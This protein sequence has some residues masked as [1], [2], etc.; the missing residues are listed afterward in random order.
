MRRR[1]SCLVVVML[2]FSMPATAAEAGAWSGEPLRPRAG[3]SLREPDRRFVSDVFARHYDRQVAA[4]CAAR[5]A[6]RADAAYQIGWLLLNA[7]QSE[8]A[9]AWLQQAAALGHERAAALL[10]RVPRS[11]H[12]PAVSCPAPARAPAATAG[13]AKP[14]LAP[15]PRT[16]AIVHKV[17]PRYGLDP[18]LV[19]AVIAVES[20][21]RA[22]A[23]SPKNARGLMQL[24]PE[25]AERFAVAD[26]FDPVQNIRG[27]ARYLS[28]L[29]DLFE[30]D[31]ALALAGYNAGENTVRRYGGVPPFAETRTY[32]RAVQ[33]YYEQLKLA[34]GRPAGRQAAGLRGAG[35]TAEA[36][37]LAGSLL[38]P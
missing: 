18:D 37:R 30:G 29:L 25:T 20:G 19:I 4:Y 1:V 21:F 5:G 22:D 15:P 10:D 3:A 23:V 28:W 27:G 24:I 33:D 32:V 38:L 6:E 13:A 2:G 34:S 11:T 16:K 31:L 7:R 12:P 9:G 26:V 14:L 8:P 17:A 36:G 35:K